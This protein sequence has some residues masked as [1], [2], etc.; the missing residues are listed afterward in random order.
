MKRRP[1]VLAALGTPLSGA[2]THVGGEVRLAR[3]SFRIEARGWYPYEL[4]AAA[5]QAAGDGAHLR[6]VD[7]MTDARAL[8]EMSS[9]QGEVDVVVA[10]PSPERDRL[11][12][13]VPVPLYRGLFGWRLLVVR[14]GEAE[15]FSGMRQVADLAPMTFL[16]G[17]DWPDTEILR[18]NGLQVRTGPR[19][20]ALYTLLGTGEGDAFPRGVTE[21]PGE[22]AAS[23]DRF[24]VVPGLVLHYRADL[25]FYVRREH[26]SLA[27]RLHQALHRLQRA[28]THDRLLRS[29]HGDAIAQAGLAQRHVL[30]LRN[31]LLPASLTALPAQAW[32]VP[33]P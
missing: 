3:P 14:R 6:A 19:V 26:R 25:F 23:G 20:D 16:Q 2:A 33:T 5:L 12:R 4:L 1:L 27:H 18:A 28:G 13:A 22:L 9:P 17:E 30:R 21:P 24:E 31:P 29:L 8:R 32:R 11:L 10:M 15:R 7:R